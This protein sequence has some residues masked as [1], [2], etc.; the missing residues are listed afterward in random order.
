MQASFLDL[1]NL[2]DNVHID[3]SSL[4][5][6][7]FGSEQ[8]SPFYLT[9]SLDSPV[10]GLLRPPIVDQLRKEN[11]TTRAH[12]LRD[13]W[14]IIEQPP[15]LPN[16]LPIYRVSFNYWV[17][18]AVKRSAIMKA[19]CERWRDTG[20]FEDV[21]GPKKWRSEPYPV[22]SNPFGKHDYPGDRD[23]GSNYA[24]EMERSACA[25][26]GVVTYGVHMTIYRDSNEG[27]KQI[28][29]PTRATTK[30]T[31]EFSHLKILATKMAWLSR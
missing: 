6:T 14:S 7:K 11:E 18:T 8:L 24:F 13:T 5:D 29:I 25:L 17:D 23:S 30:P 3:W 26:F 4:T 16:G 10:I 20:L 27:L 1:V 19:L 31:Y 21:C 15:G 2:C 9:T 22:Y 12:G 28:W